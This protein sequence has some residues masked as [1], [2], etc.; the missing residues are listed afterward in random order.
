VSGIGNMWLAEMLWHARVSP[1]ARVGDVSDESLVGA[2][3][4]VGRAMAASVAGGRQS[5]A[6]YRRA[7]RACPRCGG[8]IRPR[9]PGDATRTAYW[10][11]TCQWGGGGGGGI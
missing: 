9:G 7:G 10:C 5:R 4:W 6:V 3:D 11:P 8:A 2:L 1:W